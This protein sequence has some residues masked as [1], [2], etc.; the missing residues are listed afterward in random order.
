[1]A[2]QRTLDTLNVTRDKS[3]LDVPPSVM[4]EEVGN[5]NGDH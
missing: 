3:S 4:L 1:M 2:D 5:G